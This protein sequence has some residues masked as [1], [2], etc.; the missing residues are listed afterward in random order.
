MAKGGSACKA[1]VVRK[2]VKKQGAASKAATSAAEAKASKCA[3]S[4]VEENGLQW[5]V[6]HLT[7]NAGQILYCKAQLEAGM[8]DK[9]EAHDVEQKTVFH[10]T[11]TTFKS[12]P[13]YFMADFLAHHAGFSKEFLD[14][15][16]FASSGQLR[17]AFCFMTGVSD[18]M[19]WPPA[20]H[21]IELLTEFLRDQLKLLGNRHLKFA[22][23]V[24]QAGKVDWMKATPY[25]LDW[26]DVEDAASKR[27]THIRYGSLTAAVTTVN[28]TTQFSVAEPWDDMRCAFSG[29]PVI[30]PMLHSFFPEGGYK[31]YWSKVHFKTVAEELER[32]WELRQRDSVVR[33]DGILHKVSD[34]RKAKA[35]VQARGRTPAHKVVTPLRID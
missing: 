8:C 30:K 11:Y 28:I 21:R 5:I 19:W 18:F 16:D 34:D 10:H 4:I 1:P 12:L 9:S 26:S 22:S 24:D 7:A 29:D 14:N 2:T 20:L 25:K 13:K 31:V 33:T 17:H 3:L 32:K 23:V 35:K 6:N 27:V 15:L